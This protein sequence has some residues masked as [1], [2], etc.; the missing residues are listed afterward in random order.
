M[1]SYTED[2]AA[3]L[4]D[5]SGFTAFVTRRLEHGPP[6]IAA[7]WKKSCRQLSPPLEIQ[8]SK[9]MRLRAGTAHARAAR[10]AA[11]RGWTKR[12]SPSRI[13]A[14]DAGGTKLARATRAR[15]SAAL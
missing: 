3:V 11:D 5:I 10:E 7:R 6:I 13:A 8:K 12:S 14:P 9:A 15:A 1:K 4:A 2:G